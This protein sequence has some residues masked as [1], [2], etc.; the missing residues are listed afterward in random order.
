MRVG[1]HDPDS[2]TVE[3]LHPGV[4][5]VDAASHQGREFIDHQYSVSGDAVHHDADGALASCSAR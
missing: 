5:H 1:T 3:V 4:E 2:R